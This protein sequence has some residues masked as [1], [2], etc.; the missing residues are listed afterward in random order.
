MKTLL[1]WRVAVVLIDA[2]EQ[3]VGFVHR[4]DDL[5]ARRSKRVGNHQRGDPLLPVGLGV[6]VVPLADEMRTKP[7]VCSKRLDEFALAGSWRTIDENIG[8]NA[9]RA[10]LAP[11]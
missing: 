11:Y 7:E 6:S 10:R 3:I 1:P 5:L 2:R 8:S 9:G 4:D